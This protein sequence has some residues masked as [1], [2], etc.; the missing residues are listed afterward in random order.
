MLYIL[1]HK[2]TFGT[3]ILTISRSNITALK[4]LVRSYNER[5]QAIP[6]AKIIDANFDNDYAE[7]VIIDDETEWWFVTTYKEGNI[8]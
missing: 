2:S 4:E 6:N 5:L 7:I 8:R 1:M 3:E